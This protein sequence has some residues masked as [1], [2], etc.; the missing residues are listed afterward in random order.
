LTVAVAV[1]LSEGV[2]LAADSAATVTDATGTQIIKIY[3][4][5]DKVFPLGASLPST[6]ARAG[7]AIYGLASIGLQS[8]GSYVR[9]FEQGPGRI[10]LEGDHALKDVAEELRKFLLEKYRDA[11]GPT[12]EQEAGVPFDQIPDDQLQGKGLGIVLGGYSTDGRLPEIWNTEIPLHRAN[13]SA[14]LKLAPGQFASS[15]FA[16]SAPI[17]RYIKGFDAA[18]LD[19]LLALMRQIRGGKDYS[20]Q[21]LD[22]IKN[23]VEQGEYVIPFGAMPLREGIAYARFLV[24]LVINHHRFAVGAPV[25]GGKVS[26]GT[27]SYQARSFEMLPA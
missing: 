22:Q 13:D 4:N 7:V 3:E 9:E 23:L 11:L 12:L 2:I 15:W 21:E 24:E 16:L 6:T 27:V 25:V 5:A 20:P 17:T 26:I 19:G 1:N 10:F 8:I 14:Q 18:L